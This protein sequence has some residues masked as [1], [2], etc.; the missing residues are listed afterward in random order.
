MERGGTMFETTKT[1]LQR[2]RNS[3]LAGIPS[4]DSPIFI[5]RDP[6]H[7]RVILNFLRNNLTANI[8]TLPTSTRDLNDFLCEANQDLQ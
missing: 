2:D 1:T 7:F 8:H 4:S 5:D 3:L 6:T